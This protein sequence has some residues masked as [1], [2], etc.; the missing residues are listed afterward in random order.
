MTDYTGDGMSDFSKSGMWIMRVMFVLIT[1]MVGGYVIYHWD[2][3][4][5]CLARLE[6]GNENPFLDLDPNECVRH[7]GIE[8]TQK[9]L[10]RATSGSQYLA[11]DGSLRFAQIH[12]DGVCSK[13]GTSDGLRLVKLGEEPASL[14]YGPPGTRIQRVEFVHN[15]VRV[16]LYG[17]IRDADSGQ[18]LVD[19]PKSQPQ[20]HSIYWKQCEMPNSGVFPILIESGKGSSSDALHNY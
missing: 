3:E 8:Q 16:L 19:I 7:L 5:R 14:W 20:E 12:R 11:F 15:S 4:S 13:A 1:I 17:N 2:M 9:L 18:H 10:L 6:Q